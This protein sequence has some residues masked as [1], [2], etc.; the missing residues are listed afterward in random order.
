VSGTSKVVPS[1]ASTRQ[2]RYHDPR[3]AGS[4]NGFATCSN[5]AFNGTAPSLTR[6]REIAAVV[7]TRHGL[8]HRA[9]HDN[10]SVSNRATS[11]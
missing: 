9:A 11:S 4:A 5:N 3:V 7:G 10:P 6:A 1:T 8:D 2:V